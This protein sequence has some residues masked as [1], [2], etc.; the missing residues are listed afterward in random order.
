MKRLTFFHYNY[1]PQRPDNFGV[2]NVKRPTM[3]SKVL[4]SLSFHIQTLWLFTV[5]DHKPLVYPMTITGVLNMLAGPILNAQESTMPSLMSG[6]S[7]VPITLFWVWLNFLVFCIGN[8]RL[9]KAIAED[10]INKA[11][12]PLPS[13][14]LTEEQ[15]KFLHFGAH[16][17]ALAAGTW[18]GATEYTVALMVL[19]R[20]YNEYDGGSHCVSRNAINAF[21]VVCFALGAT[22]V[23]Y[24]ESTFKI[25]TA[26]QQWYSLIALTVF[27]TLQV[28]DLSD[29]EGDIARGRRTIPIVLGD[30][31][32]RWTV[33][34]PMIS[35]SLYCPWFW[36]LPILGFV[37]P[38]AAGSTICY[39]LLVWRD[40]NAD[41]VTYKLWGLWIACLLTLP[42]VKREI[43]G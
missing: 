14:R 30:I 16:V 15:A 1:S 3:Q 17:L 8:Q 4:Q 25:N 28:Q 11:W 35:W 37:G 32:S 27:S 41:R 18:L 31:P 5:S 40:S 26:A 34:L 20:A 36:N 24:N 12:R 38:V 19:G 22:E 10:A 29:Q 43:G 23:A 33:V 13:K 9:P 7:R 39:R 6:I 2:D 42:F 21:A